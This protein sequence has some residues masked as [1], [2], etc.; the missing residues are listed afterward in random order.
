MGRWLAATLLVLVPATA[1]RADPAEA[2]AYDSSL[3]FEA[4]VGIGRIVQTPGRYEPTRTVLAMAYG[5]GWRHERAAFTL[6]IS[7]VT[8]PSPGDILRPDGDL[9]AP[10]A[11]SIGPAVQVWIRPWCWMGGGLGVGGGRFGSDGQ[12]N[13]GRSGGT[14]SFRLGVA[15]ELTRSS[16]VSVSSEI[17]AIFDPTRVAFDAAYVSV[18][19]GVQYGGRPRM[20]AETR[21]ARLRGTHGQALED[22]R[23]E[24]HAAAAAGDCAKV[25]RLAV[26]VSSLD[27]E[28]YR[29]VFVA[30]VGS[31]LGD[32]PP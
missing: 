12:E 6:R 17:T 10:T 16:T 31:C 14:L 7:G 15:R 27:A 2:V 23:I 22:L 26:Q 3:T 18:L 30:D 21:A 29:T 32:N 13:T 8:V 11:I 4:E 19:V 28:L 1:V 24:A 9:P 20:L 25:K 5:V